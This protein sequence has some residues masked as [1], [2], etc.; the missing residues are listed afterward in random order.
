MPYQLL[1]PHSPDELMRDA[2]GWLSEPAR[3]TLT[4]VEQWD[5][6]SQITALEDTP[7]NRPVR[8]YVL[9]RATRSLSADGT[10]EGFLR[11]LLTQGL[12]LGAALG[13]SLFYRTEE[14]L[15]SLA[16]Y[17]VTEAEPRGPAL[18][19]AGSLLGQLFQMVR[20]LDSS[21]FTPEV[22][23]GLV[24]SAMQITGLDPW[25]GY[26]ASAF[27]HDITGEP[28]N[29]RA[30]KHL[31]LNAL[32]RLHDQLESL[33]ENTLQPE[34]HEG[35]PFLLPRVGDPGDYGGDTARRLMLGFNEGYD[36]EARDVIWKVLEARVVSALASGEPLA[37]CYDLNSLLEEAVQ[38]HDE[39]EET[40]EAL[41][42]GAQGEL[43]L[44]FER[45][46]V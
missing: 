30:R 33:R 7:E 26:A 27:V 12:G 21:Q 5:L 34:Y 31:L 46:A 23:H 25:P 44:D 38:L 19:I 18:D 1:T 6:Y 8:T 28:L 36:Q 39:R 20:P 40:D 24:E 10:S 41:H 17:Y 29:D 13:I 22:G 43:V 42:H 37:N 32:S 9:A 11:R 35:T 45:W 16:P 3:D 4:A 2:R 15:P 14:E